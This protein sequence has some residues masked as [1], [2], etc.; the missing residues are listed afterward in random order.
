MNNPR[1]AGPADSFFHSVIK[2]KFSL[3][4]IRFIPIFDKEIE[5]QIGIAHIMIKERWMT[6]RRLRQIV[7]GVAL[8]SLLCLI[9]VA[10]ATGQRQQLEF[11]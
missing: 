8:V 5:R 7:L 11:E 2:K 3:K 10:T 4:V 9:G 1:P 6:D